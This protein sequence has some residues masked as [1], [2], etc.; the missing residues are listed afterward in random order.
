MRSH[1][2]CQSYQEYHSCLFNHMGDY[3]SLCAILTIKTPAPFEGRRISVWKPQGDLRLLPILVISTRR[4]SKN[5][6]C[7]SLLRRISRI[8]NLY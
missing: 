4:Y 8:A 6:L 1:D 2:I 7:R 3:D 5:D